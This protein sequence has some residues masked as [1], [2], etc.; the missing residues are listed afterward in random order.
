MVAKIL[1]KAKAALEELNLEKILAAYAENAVFED[2]SAGE[3]LTDKASFRAYFEQL[4]SLPGVAFSDISILDGK[5]FAV[6][7]WTWSGLKRQS[8]E[9]YEVRGASVIEIRQGKIVRECIYYDPTLTM[10]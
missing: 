4:F 2:V 6:L 3:R 8:K 5:H 1:L 10:K 9:R 7:E